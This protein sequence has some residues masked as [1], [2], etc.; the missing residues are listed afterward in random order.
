MPASNESKYIKEVWAEN[1][2]EEMAVLRDLVEQYPYL[3]MEWWPDRLATFGQAQITITK[4]SD[5]M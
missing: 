4:H 1:L 3:A 2:E 5:A